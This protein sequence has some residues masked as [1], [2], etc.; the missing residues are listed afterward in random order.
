MTH[1][2]KSLILRRDRFSREIGVVSGTFFIAEGNVNKRRRPTITFCVS[3]FWKHSQ[4][5]GQ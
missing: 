2:E 1:D 5:S 4:V 3:C